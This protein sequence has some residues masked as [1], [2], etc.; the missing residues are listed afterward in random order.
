[1]VLTLTKEHARVFR[2]THRDN[3]SWILDN[4]MHAQS[5]EVS[6]PNFRN[7]GNPEL[8]ERRTHRVIEVQPGGTLSD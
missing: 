8:I 1:M 4:G 5:G 3:V 6:D 2:I 7:I